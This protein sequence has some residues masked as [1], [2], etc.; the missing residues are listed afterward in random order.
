MAMLQKATELGAD[1]FIPLMTRFTSIRIPGPRLEGRQLG[2][3]IFT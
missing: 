3:R 2:A 1:E